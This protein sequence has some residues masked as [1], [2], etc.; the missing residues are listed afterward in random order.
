MVAYTFAFAS[1]SQ[2]TKDAYGTS[3]K[4]S[5]KNVGIGIGAKLDVNRKI[6]CEELEVVFDVP[7]FDYIFKENYNLRSLKEV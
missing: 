4:L 1:C 6:R 3:Y 7:S 2:F 5:K